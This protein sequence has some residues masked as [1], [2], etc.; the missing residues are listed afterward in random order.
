MVFNVNLTPPTQPGKY[1][2]SKIKQFMLNGSCQSLGIKLKTVF[3]P[4]LNNL[5]SSLKAIIDSK[6]GKLKIQW[7]SIQH[8]MHKQFVA[9]YDYSQHNFRPISNPSKTLSPKCYSPKSQLQEQNKQDKTFPVLYTVAWLHSTEPQTT[10]NDIM[11]NTAKHDYPQR[12]WT[13]VWCAM[14]NQN[15]SNNSTCHNFWST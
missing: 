6:N 14:I 15:D 9:L 13:Q 1:Q 7:I 2:A 4:N 3:G 5:N 12:R 10:Q 11:I 8:S